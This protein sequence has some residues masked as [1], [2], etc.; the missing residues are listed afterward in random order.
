MVERKA[1]VLVVDTPSDRRA[2][3]VMAYAKS[4][5]VGRI[6]ITSGAGLLSHNCPNLPPEAIEILP[7]HHTDTQ[8]I[9]RLAEERRPDLIEVGQE[10]AIYVG[11]TDALRKRNFLTFGVSRAVGRYEWDKPFARREMQRYGASE[12]LPNFQVFRQPKKGLDYIKR[13]FREGYEG[14]LFIKAAYPALGKGV[15]GVKNT[16]EAYEAFLKLIALPNRAGRAFLVEDGVGGLKAEEF[17]GYFIGKRLNK[18]GY[19]QDHKPVNDNDQGPNTGGMGSVGPISLITPTL[20]AEIRQHIVKPLALS[21]QNRGLENRGV[22]YLGG[23]YDPD[24]DKVWNIE[25]N[26]RNGGS[27]AASNIPGLLNDYYELARDIAEGRDKDLDIQYD[28]KVRVAVAGTSLGYPDD[29]K[30]VVGRK[31]QGLQGVIKRGEVLVLGAG[32]DDDFRVIGGRIFWLVA[33]AN[34]LEKAI[35]N[36]YKN[37]KE[38]YIQGDSKGENLLHYRRDIGFKEL[39]RHQ[40]LNG[41]IQN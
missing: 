39:R 6:L 19:W 40:A 3:A 21:M 14:R 32:I 23:M 31:V 5:H 2:V 36:I 12:H 38:V 30:R 16:G 10:D 15:Y 9:L 7:I 34:S 26:T 33:E 13:R 41:G 29:Y 35:G 20:D 1:T 4:P 17:S 22:I 24:A 25:W 27:E 18:L 28:G 11:V 37:M 8:N